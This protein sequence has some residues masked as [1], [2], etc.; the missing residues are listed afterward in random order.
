MV[1]AIII[2]VKDLTAGLGYS[3]ERDSLKNGW[4]WNERGFCLWAGCI[5]YL[6]DMGLL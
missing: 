6:V 5:C 2:V 1:R 4:C 3:G